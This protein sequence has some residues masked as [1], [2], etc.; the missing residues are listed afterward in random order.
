MLRRNIRIFVLYCKFFATYIIREK[1]L[2]Q[3]FQT[4]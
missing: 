2:V 3:S 1:S 4:L